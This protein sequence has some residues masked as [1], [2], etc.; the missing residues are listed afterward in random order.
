[1]AAFADRSGMHVA[2]RTDGGGRRGYGHLVRTARVARGLLDRDHEVTCL[3]VTPD[4]AASTLPDRTAVRSLAGPGAD[5][6]GA[7]LDAM[8][9]DV[10]LVDTP[11]VTTGSLEAFATFEVGLAVILDDEPTTV[12][13]D[14]LINPHVYATEIDYTWIDSE[15]EWCLGLDYMALSA[16]FAE[17]ARPEL[18]WRDPPERGLVLMGGSDVGNTTPAAL[19]AFDGFDG[20]VDVIVGP[21]FDNRDEIRETARA[22]DVPVTQVEAPDDVAP[23]MAEADVAVSALGLVAYELLATDT[24]FVGITQAPDQR[25]KAHAFRREDCAVVLEED[26]SA[27][28]IRAATSRLLTD[29]GLRRRLAENGHEMVDVDGTNRIC[30]RLEG[31]AAGGR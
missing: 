16:S 28:D 3:T 20:S 25:P 9:A 29:T 18:R 14:L 6:V 8:A 13:C 21:G 26:A 22:V 5:A 7:A 11:D 2:V 19:R 15:P 31:L 27:G 17:Y 23:Y 1:M 30:D 12:C 10:L 24:P 4:S